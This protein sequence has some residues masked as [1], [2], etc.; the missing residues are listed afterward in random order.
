MTIMFHVKPD[1]G[2]AYPMAKHVPCMS[3]GIAAR[4]PWGGAPRKPT[5]AVREL[6][7]DTAKTA[8]IDTHSR[9]QERI[10]GNPG[11]SAWS[12]SVLLPRPMAVEYNKKVAPA[13]S[14]GH[15][16]SA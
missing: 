10:L 14:G 5:A 1:G 12:Y 4:R 13:R 16:R 9:L 15:F 2:A 7:A 8:S 11:A 6:S 3:A